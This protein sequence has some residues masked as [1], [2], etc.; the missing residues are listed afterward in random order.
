[1]ERSAYPRMVGNRRRPT[2]DAPANL[3]GGVGF[4]SSLAHNP[5]RLHQGS[6]TSP[7]MQ[8][9]L[10]SVAVKTPTKL[11]FEPPTLDDLAGLAAAEKQNF[12]PPPARLGNAGNNHPH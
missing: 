3:R 6:G 12:S 5:Q 9:A 11:E 10:Y 4:H 1:M 2:Q 8:S 7:E